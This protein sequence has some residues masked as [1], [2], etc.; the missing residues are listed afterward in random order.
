MRTGMSNL[1][2]AETDKFV[3]ED[4]MIWS[5]EANGWVIPAPIDTGSFCSTGGWLQATDPITSNTAIM[6]IQ[7]RLRWRIS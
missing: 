2:F 1:S 6:P 7:G 4:W 3:A 5:N